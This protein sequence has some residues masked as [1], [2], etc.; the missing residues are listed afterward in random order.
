MAACWFSSIQSCLSM[1][2]SRPRRR[3]RFVSRYKVRS[4]LARQEFHKLGLVALMSATVKAYRWSRWVWSPT[5][6]AKL[7]IT[8]GSEVSCFCDTED[9]NRCFSTNQLMRRVS[10]CDK[11]CRSE[12]HTSELQ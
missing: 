4:K 8:S 1:L 9:I 12:E 2:F 7:W 6:W 11:L 3:A 5:K 10:R